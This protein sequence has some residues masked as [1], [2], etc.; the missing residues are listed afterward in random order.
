MGHVAVQEKR[1]TTPMEQC[2]SDL[3]EMNT[4]TVDLLSRVERV[5]AKFYGPKPKSDGKQL[6]SP[7]G[8]YIQEVRYHSNLLMNRLQILS[9]EFTA[10]EAI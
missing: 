4:I 2:L 5:K 9:K 8:G 3:Q 6:D 1:D 7:N 10:F